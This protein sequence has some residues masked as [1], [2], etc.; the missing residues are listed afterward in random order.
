MINFATHL[1]T[2]A[3]KKTVSY[4]ITELQPYI[5]W[6]YFHHAWQLCDRAEQGR[7]RAEAE[8]FIDQVRDRYAVHALLYVGPAGSDGDDILFTASPEEGMAE[9]V[10]LP[11][12]RQQ[13]PAGEGRPCLCL[14]D[15]LRPVGMP[16]DDHGVASRAAMFATTVDMGMETD[17]AH[18]DYLRMMAQLV[19][20]RLAEAAAE[21][22]HLE[23][24]TRLWGYARGERL[25]MDELHAERFQGIRPAVGYP[26]LPDASLN[27][28]LA[29]ALG[30]ESIGIR[31][32]ESGAMKPH[33]SVSGLMLAH[34]E[35]RYFDIGPVGDDQL[36]DYARRRGVPANLIRKFLKNL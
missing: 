8:R 25:S 12:L 20:D 32:T 5:N 30:M 4:T 3:L 19:A 14:S 28:V 21:K 6:P 31:L 29:R 23:V 34:P 15:F 2:E 13:H 17:F 18:D 24:R 22:L 16:G 33:A 35:A 36:R 1:T 10:R 27:F 26:S 11:M 9:E 7:M